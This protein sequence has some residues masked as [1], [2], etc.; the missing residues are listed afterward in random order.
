[1]VVP[2]IA[3]IGRGLASA[4]SI[5]AK[6]SRNMANSV[7]NLRKS[8]SQ[9]NAAMA[10]AQREQQMR[11][12]QMN[13]FEQQYEA[14]L[15]RQMAGMGNLQASQEK[16]RR[17]QNV[18]SKALRA[19]RGTGRGLMTGLTIGSAAAGATASGVR[20][21]ARALTGLNA[22][23]FMTIVVY[24]LDLSTFFQLPVRIRMLFY[25]I[26]T[27]W[28]GFGVFKSEIGRFHIE[29]LRIPFIISA[30]AFGFPYLPNI[31]GLS[32]LANNIIFQVILIAV[33][34]PLWIIYLTFGVGGTRVLKLGLAALII[35]WAVIGWDTAAEAFSGLENLPV[36]IDVIDG[37]SKLGNSFTKGLSNVVTTIKS[38]PGQVKKSFDRAVLYTVGGDYYTGNVDRNVKEPL[39]V[40]I[41]KVKAADPKYYSG[42]T[43]VVYGVLRA[44]TIDPS[45]PITIAVSCYE[46]DDNSP[47][48]IGTV[49]RNK[50]TVESFDV[51]DLECNMKELKEGSHVIKLSSEFENF[52]TYGYVKAYF[53]DRQRLRELLRENIDPLDRFGITEKKPV[54]VYTNGPIMIGMGT[55]S[56]IVGIGK[57][58]ETITPRLGITLDNNW[59][60]Q[61]IEIKEIYLQVPKQMSITE[62]KSACGPNYNVKLVENKD[63]SEEVAKDDNYKTYKLER[64]PARVKEAKT[65]TTILCNLNVDNSEEFLGATPIA[66][67]YFRAKINYKYKITEQISITVN[68]LPSGYISRKAQPIAIDSTKSVGEISH[69]RLR[70]IID[71]TTAIQSSLKEPCKKHAESI[72]QSSKKNGIDP[73]FTLSII[74]QESGCNENAY[75]LDPGDEWFG[76][77]K[78][79]KKNTAT[80]ATC[81]ADREK[82]P[83]SNI[84]CGLKIFNQEYGKFKD[85]C[86]SP[87]ECVHPYPDSCLGFK[88]DGKCN[89]DRFCEYTYAPTTTLIYYTIDKA[90]LRAYNGWGKTNINYADE[91][92]DR[93]NTLISVAKLTP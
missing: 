36:K 52:P 76:L 38:I 74:V 79:S 41:E 85:S 13:L 72:I 43:I 71:A 17:W 65:P 11:M 39:G 70:K 40:Y 31:P 67:K 26:I 57:G 6:Y 45:I 44:R 73:L 34:G 75:S 91:I 63:F 50:F 1:M 62:G 68:R 90:G 69:E 82:N 30:I 80:I 59:K 15:Q 56:E 48:K 66:I 12:S 21:G 7:K 64:D 81:P 22:F 58:I 5:V 8:S 23:F 60:G 35:F 10:Q 20:A 27:L 18:G 88:C 54:A 61:V 3:G 86:S 55:S 89:K 93:Y 24:L 84:D 32:F 2:I 46:G 29:D 83:L 9:Q 25:T 37:M 42:D 14:S 28:A 77:M 87:S 4:G 53:M 33:F 47:D 49:A 19:A 16:A 92:W 51:F 78:V